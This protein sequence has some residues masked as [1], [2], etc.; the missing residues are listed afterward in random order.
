[1]LK[2]STWVMVLLLV[3]SFFALVI[4]QYFL[5]AYDLT[6]YEYTQSTMPL[7]EDEKDY[8]KERT[9][10][11]FASDNNAPPF[12]YVD[13]QTG[14]YQGLV[15]D[16]ASALS[17][18]LE[19]EIQFTPMSWE[20]AVQS[21]VNGSADLCDMFP[22][23]ER[24]KTMI[25]SDVLYTIRAVALVNMD[26]HIAEFEHEIMDISVAVPAGDYAL[27]YL[28]IHMPKVEVVETT[29]IQQ[30]IR[31]LLNGKVD[32]VVGD[33]PVVLYHINQME[34]DS[35]VRILPSMVYEQDVCLAINPEET[36]LKT[37]VNKGILQLKKTRFLEKIQQKWFGIS[38]PIEKNVIPANLLLWTLVIVSLLVIGVLVFTIW[39]NTLKKEIR[40][41]TIELTKSRNDLVS[42]INS[43]SDA[44]VVV[45]D[46]NKI[47]YSNQ[48]FRQLVGNEEK[49]I[50]EEEADNFPILVNILATN[51]YSNE[52]LYKGH[53]YIASLVSMEMDEDLKLI[54]IKDITDMKSS[55]QQMLQQGKMIAIGQL[56]AG[57]AHEIRNPLGIIRNYN[58]I[59]ESKTR[60]QDPIID[61][62]IQSINSAVSRAV[63]I[64][65]ALLNHSRI[66]D[67]QLSDFVLREQV[68]S[69]LALESDIL[70]KNRIETS[71]D[72]PENLHIKL[73]SQSLHHILMNLISNAVDA[74]P[75]GGEIRIS[76]RLN[77]D[78]NIE[79]IF[80]DTGEGIPEDRIDS[81]FHPFF[82]TK[83]A[84]KGTGLGLYIVYNE[85][86]K[87]G[88]T[89]RAESILGI[90]TTFIIRLFMREAEERV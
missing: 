88:G 58:Y 20:D 22:S 69:I 82:T 52:F 11:R 74:M 1:M 3:L 40:K 15:L 26:S 80:S 28:A 10:L 27:E 25:F 43:L 38:A 53:Y 50:E 77:E 84:G 6:I 63:K 13:R 87:N 72:C 8:L 24:K 33:E 61:K 21:V 36:T 4:N 5:L 47:R 64:V 60:G 89:I 57:V 30:G 14:Q 71:V 54:S 81:I 75:N 45:S 35:Y 39:T 73:K 86:T 62:S 90:G 76:C 48:A 78:K 2:R 46:R 42:T 83:E 31:L 17:V 44:I 12:A 32:M 67:D 9:P 41:R 59:L 70:K 56:A 29:D 37:I 7:T 79:M 68:E 66:S 55:Q 34:V 19:T 23:E 18:Q 51:K 16:Y 65:E 49:L 85:V